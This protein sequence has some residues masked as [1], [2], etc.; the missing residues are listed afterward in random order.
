MLVIFDYAIRYPEAFPLKHIDAASVAEELLK[1]FSQ[2][3]IPKEL[4]DQGMNFISK[5]LLELY[6]MLYTFNPQT[7]DLVKRFN[8]TLKLMLQKAK[9]EEG[10][11]WDTLLP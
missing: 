4:T 9:L 5:L 2:V 8:R 10:K 1:V 7:D 11:D 6:R 3:G